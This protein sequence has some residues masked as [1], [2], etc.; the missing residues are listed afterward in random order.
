[1]NY[2]DED[3]VRFYTRETVTWLSLEYEGQ[4][5]MSL[6][7]HGK[8]NRSGVFDCGGHD[9]SHAVTL[10]VRCPLEV[11]QKGLKRLLD[12]GTWV[13]HNGQLVWP[14]YVHAQHC[15]RS[16]RARKR[17]SRENSA[18]EALGVVS[19][20]VTRGHD[21]SQVVT[22]KPKPKQKP[23][24]KPKPRG[25]ERP[26][27]SV[28]T[29]T[30]QPPTP[31]SPPSVPQERPAAPTDSRPAGDPPD[32]PE[33]KPGGIAATSQAAPPAAPL[34]LQARAALWLT[35][36][37]R[38][39]LEAPHPETWPEV[40]QLD[41]R[42]RSAFGIARSVRITGRED[43]RVSKPLALWAAGLTQQDLLDAIDGAAVDPYLQ[44]TPSQRSVRWIFDNADRVQEM[45]LKKPA[46]PPKAS[47]PRRR[48]PDAAEAALAAR[49]REQ[50]RVALEQADAAEVAGATEQ[51]KAITHLAGSLFRG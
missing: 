46:P 1:M 37:T 42:V 16:D 29:S 23:K 22:P 13:L 38:A 26:P 34:T 9:P 24:P 25:G 47:A 21:R 45:I 2:P 14:N 3:Y 30:E 50:N 20:A 48:A 8:F 44:R 17:E 5:V 4:T 12:T 40:L 41:E 11:A 49:K 28:T 35:D 51:A 33:G 18:L 19:H 15:K 27:E 7:L 10:A 31:S 43:P 32:A 36:P 6:M 39:T